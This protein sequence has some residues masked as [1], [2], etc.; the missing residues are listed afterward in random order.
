[1]KTLVLGASPNPMRYSHKAVKQLRAHNIE[2]VAIGKRETTI[3]DVPVITGKPQIEQ[4]HTVTLYLNAS[5]QEEYLDY[6][7]SQKP[8]RIIFNPGTYNFKLEELA[9]REGITT[10]SDCTLIMLASDDY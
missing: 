3:E 1:M 7:I 10:V 2:V 8:K 6:I 9:E 5:N 4:L